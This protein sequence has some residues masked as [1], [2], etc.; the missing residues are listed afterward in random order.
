MQL[1]PRA[2]IDLECAKVRAPIDDTIQA[3]PRQRPPAQGN[4]DMGDTGA[5]MA[6]VEICQHR[7]ASAAVGQPVGLAAPALGQS[8]RGTVLTVGRQGL[9]ADDAAAKSVARVIRVLVA[10]DPACSALAAA[11]S[12]SRW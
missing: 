12:D 6:K 2:R 9:I 4:V 3:T 10:L 1:L 8:L 7:I 5:M 11:M